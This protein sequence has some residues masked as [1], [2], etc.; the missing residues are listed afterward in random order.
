MGFF[1]REFSF[2]SILDNLPFGI[3]FALKRISEVQE[4]RFH[5]EFGLAETLIQRATPAQIMRLHEILDQMR[6]E[7]EAGD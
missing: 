6:A 1:V 3:L 7:G 4:I 5:I 2:D